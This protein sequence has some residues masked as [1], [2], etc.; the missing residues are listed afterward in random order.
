MASWEA[1]GEA[2]GGGRGRRTVLVLTE[3]LVSAHHSLDDAEGLEQSRA[4]EEMTADPCVT[5]F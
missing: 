2:D 5:D 3:A 1:T 4:P